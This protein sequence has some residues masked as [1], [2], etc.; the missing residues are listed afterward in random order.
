MPFSIPIG[1]RLKILVYEYVSGGGLAGKPLNPSIL[2][3]GFGMLKTLSAD[4]QAAGHSVTVSLDSRI[5]QF[6]PLLKADQIVTTYTLDQSNA[7]IKKIVNSVDAACIIA[8]ESKGILESI[9]GKMEGNTQLLNSPPQT[10]ATVSSKDT[11]LEDARKIGLITPQSITLSTSDKVSDTVQR[12]AEEI[13]FPAIIKPLNDAGMTG[14]SVVKR[15]TEIPSAIKKV[16][17]ESESNQF[18]AQELVEGVPASVSLISTGKQAT[19]IS[20]NRQNITLSSSEASSTY[21]GGEV[22][23]QSSLKKEAVSAAKQLVESFE[24]LRGYIGVDFILTEE[25]PVVI[26]V[27]PRLT[28][29]YIGLRE[30]IKIN[31]AQAILDAAINHNLPA[32]DEKIDGCACFSKV[33]T[34][35]LSDNALRQTFRLKNLISPPFPISENSTSF[36]IISSKGAT[37]QEANLRLEKAKRRL[38]SLSHIRSE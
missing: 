24:Y 11:L 9:V 6:Q 16:N 14:L 37:S 22:P 34:T 26:E 2:C 30:V 18:M 4:F 12:I 32:A 13:G 1:T 21:D 29:S 35:A 23:L 19:A 5:S 10:I 27:N 20:L 38:L 25:D 31:P 8:P 15:K 28:T 17:Q 36:G 7:D 3:E 33:K